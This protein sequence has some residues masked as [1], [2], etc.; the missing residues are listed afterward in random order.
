METWEVLGVR[1]I[2]PGFCRQRSSGGGLHAKEKQDLHLKDFFFL[3]PW[4]LVSL[5][6]SFSIHAVDREQI[7][8][9][10]FFRN[11]GNPPLTPRKRVSRVEKEAAQRWRGVGW[12]EGKR[13][14]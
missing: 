8:Y 7:T 9:L 13:K 3:V 14:E 5:S 4:D 10:W 2:I 1:D 12:R 11:C 6:L